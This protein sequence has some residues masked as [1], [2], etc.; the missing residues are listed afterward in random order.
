MTATFLDLAEHDVWA[1]VRL[2]IEGDTCRCGGSVLRVRTTGERRQ[3]ACEACGTRR[4]VLSDQSA[5]FVLAIAKQFGPSPSPVI[6]R[7][8]KTSA[9]AE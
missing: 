3:L 8:P 5:G 7:R 9:C 2:A 1:D 4:G 6:L